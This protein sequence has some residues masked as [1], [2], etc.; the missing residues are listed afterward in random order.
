MQAVVVQ[1]TSRRGGGGPDDGDATL[2]DAVTDLFGSDK[3]DLVLDVSPPGQP[4]FRHSGRYKIS[5][6]LGGLRAVNK[7]WRP[8][9]GLVLPV[10]VSSDRRTIEIDWDAFV[11]HGGI[12]Q[13]EQLVA[14]RGA[15]QGAAAMGKMLAKNPKLAAQQRA[16][17]LQH[18]PEQ[19]I[20]VTTGVRPADE[21]ARSISSLVQ[22]GALTADEG[23][24]FLRAAGILPPQ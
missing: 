12:D 24:D 6:R 11:A 7:N 8:L 23:N 3:W 17:A 2:F 16:M 10:Q 9:P 14:T 22:G 19:A 13:G 1:A 5:R 21:F 18:F 20:Q 4:P 15:Q